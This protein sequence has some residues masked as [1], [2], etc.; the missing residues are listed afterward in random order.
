VLIFDAR[1]YTLSEIEFIDWERTEPLL[2]LDPDPAAP[3][4]SETAD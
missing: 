4:L 1:P 3:Q 2:G